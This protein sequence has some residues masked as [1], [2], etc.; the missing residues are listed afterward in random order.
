MAD[1]SKRGPGCDDCEDGERGEHGERGKRGKRGHRGHDGHDGAIGPTG[2]AGVTGPPFQP[3]FV[4]DLTIFIYARLSGSDETGD[5]SLANPFRTLQRAIRNVPSHIPAGTIYRVDITGIGLEQLPTEYVF[6]VFVGAESSPGQFDFTQRFFHLF[7]SVNV[8]ADPQ[9]FT[10]ASGPNVIAAGATIVD[11]NTDLIAINVPGAGWTPGNLVGKFAIG[12]GVATQHSVIW[13]N[14]NDTIFLTRTSTPTFPIQIM[15]P[16]AQLQAD[17]RPAGFGP[18]NGLQDGAINVWNTQMA[19][20]GLK[21]NATPAP[22]G[23]VTDFA[24]WG[25]HISGDTPAVVLQLCDLPGAGITTAEW[26][27]TRQCYLPGLLFAMAPNLFTQCF[28]NRSFD[29]GGLPPGA[30]VTVWGGRGGDSLFRQV[31]IKETVPLHYR[32]LFDIFASS[33]IAVLELINVQILDTLPELPPGDDFPINDGVLWNG[34]VGRMERVNISRS[35][36]PL[37]GPPGSA[38][39]VKGNAAY[40]RLRSVTGTGYGEVGCEVVDGGN[41]EVDDAGSPPTTLT[42]ALGDVLVG[43]LGVLPWPAPYPAANYADYVSPLAQGARL[44]RKS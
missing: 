15:E 30:G 4:E 41:V 29:P 39:K 2:P 34:V 12:A 32:D 25:L 35:V 18:F 44:W 28:I 38:L 23:P 5:G 10:P 42:G 19:L 16:S 26:T 37:F 31:V 33:S 3:P 20:L 24:N 36:P 17:K 27:R 7:T 8:Q 11:P 43:S 9:L 40:M 21:V 14:T 1:F 6:P 13:Q 22:I